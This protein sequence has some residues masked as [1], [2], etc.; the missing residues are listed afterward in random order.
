MSIARSR[1]H[2]TVR[3]PPAGAST[4]PAEASTGEFPCAPVEPAESSAASGSVRIDPPRPGGAQ[5][6][7]APRNPAGNGALS[8]GPDERR[9][10]LRDVSRRGM[11]LLVPADL[12]VEPG[13]RIQFDLH[14][15]QIRIGRV[16][17]RITHVSSSRNGTLAGG[18]IDRVEIVPTGKPPPPRK[19][20]VVE[21]RDESMRATLL[22]RI[23]A[24]KPVGILNLASGPSLEVLLERD[25][26]NEANVLLYGPEP[27][28]EGATDE[29]ARIDFELHKSQFIVQGAVTT[30]RDGRYLLSPPYRVFSVARR[31]C[32]RVPV[33]G[34]TAVAE[35][36]DPL[37]P[38]HK[39]TAQIVDLSPRG[40]GIVI[41]NG[42][43][44]LLPAPPFALELR[45]DDLC[46]T[47]LA[48]AHRR[49]SRLDGSQLLG[50]S[51]TPLHTRDL[52]RIAQRCQ[53]LRCS[54]LLKRREV[55]PQ[56][57]THLMRASG[58]LDLRAGTEP[59][60][61]WHDPPG[62]ESLTVDA[63]YLAETGA[64]LGHFS[65]LRLYP[66][67]WILH[68]L[69]TIGLRRGKVAYPLYVHLIEWITA[70][71]EDDCF[72][73]AYFDREKAWHK[74]MF[75]DFV[76]WVNT[77]ALSNI[78]LLD[79]LE[80]AS[81]SS[82]EPAR[83]TS[84][85]VRAARPDEL[86]FAVALARSHLSGLLA[87][88]LAIHEHSISTPNLCEHHSALGLERTRTALVVE[89]E[90]QIVGVALCETGAR[91]LS[92]FNLLN[93]ALVFFVEPMSP[94][95]QR[96]AQGALLAAV[97]DFYRSRGIADP[98][99]AAPEGNVRFP[100]AADLVVAETMACW[101]AS[102]EGIK[103]WRNFIH[104]K[105]GELARS[106]SRHAPAA[107]P[108]EPRRTGSD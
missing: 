73:I 64:P 13:E 48:E 101:A 58:Y 36:H 54:N 74:A 19:G 10:V 38:S 84:P 78:T 85:M 75:G 104:F 62:N 88:A 61:E 26:E 77:E 6:R 28:R 53:S 69:A 31:Q 52:G 33:Q 97:R 7:G 93:M 11:G 94:S 107:T 56:A 42:G 5:R 46:V 59:R 44:S 90:E 20:Q 67:T 25:P 70:L 34:A 57:L 91:W 50:L 89:T 17:L 81:D 15:D 14:Q 9:I 22:D 55:E 43:A 45:I 27:A 21:I 63:V 76:R 102:T 80:P 4:P 37:D 1:P 3:T 51:I 100:E 71:A 92:L 39:L 30:N 68:Q 40:A 79:R 87:D 105:M 83:P 66:R 103:Q 24:H 23:F 99:I 2:F 108:D 8:A 82:R 95:V 106:R 32:D 86:A 98:L 12:G 35:W 60:P 41:P 96:D 29:I 65:C 47:V 72:A 18:A 49:I 16:T